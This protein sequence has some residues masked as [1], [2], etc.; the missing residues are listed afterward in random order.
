MLDVDEC[1]GSVV[2]SFLKLIPALWIVAGG[3]VLCHFFPGQIFSRL[4]MFMFVFSVCVLPA[5]FVHKYFVS[6]KHILFQILSKIYKFLINA[7]IKS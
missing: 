4:F 7:S 6:S 5:G 2:R 3:L 1:N